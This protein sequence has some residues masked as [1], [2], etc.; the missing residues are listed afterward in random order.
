MQRRHACLGVGF[1]QLYPKW[2]FPGKG[3]LEPGKMPDGGAR[4]DRVLHYG[5]PWTWQK[6]AR[7][8]RAYSPSGVILTWWVSFWA[9]HLGWLARKLS[10][11]FPVYFLCH[12]VLPHEARFIDP[13]LTRWALAPGKGFIIH[14]E[15]NRQ[16]LMDWFPASK[17]IRLEHPIYYFDA[18]YSVPRKEARERLGINGRMLLFFGFVR[19][20]KGLDLAIE[21]LTYLEPDFN[22]L[23]L[24]VAGEF[25]EGEDR[26]RGMISRYQLEE[27][28]KI[29][30]GYLSDEDL[31][32]RISAC[33]GVILPYK[34]AT[35][36]G[37]LASAYALDR[38]VIATRTGCL[39]EMVL[40]GR[41]G[42]LCEPDDV[43]GIVSAIREFY[44]GEGPDRFR[45]GVEEARSKFT[46]DAIVDAVEE[47][48]TGA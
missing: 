30:S 42:L 37:V 2:L 8:I 46:W 3:Q 45:K 12:N 31:A 23:K 22:D 25:W 36:S 7:A 34:T 47:L 32:L 39:N 35:G 16:Q 33:D 1:K 14:S 18:N 43:Q 4:A 24:W 29:E 28:V 40:D 11:D 6:A 48:V 15:E 17:T 21:S 20:Y 13:K 9:P 19:P 38:P 10:R 5:F 44:A 27:R 41:S 26:Y